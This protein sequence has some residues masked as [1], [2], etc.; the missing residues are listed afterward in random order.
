M[1]G[2]HYHDKWAQPYYVPIVQ[3][4][5]YA[6]REEIEALRQE[7]KEMMELL[8]KALKYDKDNGEP[9]CQMDEK[10]ATLKKVA[11]IVGVDIEEVF[12]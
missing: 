3:E 6:T 8:K 4:P 9:D 2:D 7:V 5:Q 12:K 10:V 1:I 11:E